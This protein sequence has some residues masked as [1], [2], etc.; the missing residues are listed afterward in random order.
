MSVDT[1]T[2]W[3]ANDHLN[4][5]TNHHPSQLER[6]SSI[7]KGPVYTFLRFTGPDTNAAQTVNSR[8]LSTIDVF[9]RCISQTSPPLPSP[10][11][12]TPLDISPHLKTVLWWSQGRLGWWR[13]V[14]RGRVFSL[15]GLGVVG[16]R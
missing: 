3:H 6:A 15:R 13:L 1:C 14:R 2:D 9:T 7:P 12:Q 4:E 8:C 5:S 16:V 11:P 10:T